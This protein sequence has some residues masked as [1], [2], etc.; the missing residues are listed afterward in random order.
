[1]VSSNAA[2]RSTGSNC[3]VG[4]EHHDHLVTETSIDFLFL[5]WLFDMSNVL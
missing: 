1:M 2:A 5:R 4:H 3:E